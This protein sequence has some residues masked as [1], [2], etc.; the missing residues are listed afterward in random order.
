MREGE[1]EKKAPFWT[2]KGL[3]MGLIL[4]WEQTRAICICHTRS[5]TMS[6]LGFSTSAATMPESV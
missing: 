6:L 4:Q 5:F 2:R 3:G 1:E